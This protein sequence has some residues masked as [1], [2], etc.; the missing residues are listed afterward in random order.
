MGPSW[1]L[2]QKPSGVSAQMSWC[3]TECT[4]T[5]H[6]AVGTAKN[7]PPPPPLVVA[8]LN[9]KTVVN[10]RQK[11]NEIAAASVLWCREVKADGP[12]AQVRPHA[13]LLR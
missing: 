12:M 3:K 6:K 9:L 1:L 7:Q 11:V 4:I 2:L 13:H 8:A 10:H 5:G